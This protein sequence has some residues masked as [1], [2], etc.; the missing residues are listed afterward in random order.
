VD[1]PCP[2]VPCSLSLVQTMEEVID[3][4]RKFS[5][6][7]RCAPGHMGTGL[8]AVAVAAARRCVCVRQTVQGVRNTVFV[9]L[10]HL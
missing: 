9:S 6:R 10:V 2:D 8:P 3:G 4:V 7:N 5:T 1:R